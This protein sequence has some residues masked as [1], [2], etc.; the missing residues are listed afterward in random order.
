[1]RSHDDAAYLGRPAEYWIKALGDNDPLVRRLGAYALG[2]IG[3]AAPEAV[4][5][6]TEAL[7]DGV[8]FVR[9]WAAS[10]L[11]RVDPGNRRASAALIAGL[12]DQKGFVRSLAAWHLGRLST[13]LPDI[14]AAT[15]A[16]QQSSQESD[17]SVRVEMDV[18]LNRL[19]AKGTSHGWW[20]S[21]RR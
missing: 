4:P 15:S 12:K 11:A 5:I 6:L 2:E 8:N 18:A 20:P 17:L 3:P 10:A 16:L 21:Q 9:V 1:M 7:E 14:K 13:E 19:H